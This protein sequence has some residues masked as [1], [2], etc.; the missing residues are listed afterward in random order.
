[1]IRRP[2]RSTLSSSSA[3]S[4]VYKRQVPD[5]THRPPG[6]EQEAAHGGFEVEIGGPPSRLPKLRHDLLDRNL[7]SAIQPVVQPELHKSPLC[8]SQLAVGTSK[9]SRTIAPLTT[10]CLCNI[11]TLQH[12]NIGLKHVSVDA[13]ARLTRRAQCCWRT[14]GR[15]G[16]G[17]GVWPRR[18]PRIAGA[19]PCHRSEWCLVGDVLQHSP[20]MRI[21]DARR[22]PPG[23]WD[24]PGSGMANDRLPGLQE[25]LCLCR[26]PAR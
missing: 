19:R 7:E 11:A 14:G 9:E 5:S 12:R 8:S 10:R 13:D 20:A 15:T 21:R 2:P 3:A 25:L 16:M 18:R 4:D 24:S 22:P 17:P 1:M 23:P 6:V 26:T